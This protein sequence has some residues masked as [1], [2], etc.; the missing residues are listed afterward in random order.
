MKTQT[1]KN[2]FLGDRLEIFQFS[3]GF[4]GTTDTVLLAA[5]IKASYGEKVLELGCVAGVHDD[6]YW[7]FGQV[8]LKLISAIGRDVDP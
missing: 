4:R 5:S 6:R 1:T 8:E 7:R 2:K 3:E